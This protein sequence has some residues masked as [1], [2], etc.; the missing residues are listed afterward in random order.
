M[1]ESDNHQNNGGPSFV[2]SEIF[3]QENANDESVF[4]FTGL[5]NFEK[6]GVVVPR[7][8]PPHKR[9]DSKTEIRRSNRSK[10]EILLS[11]SDIFDFIA[12]MNN[13][14]FAAKNYISKLNQMHVN[15]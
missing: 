2:R 13:D 7:H 10:L 1:S 14:S 9:Q 8:L 5:L 15:P 3:D 4:D 11:Q 12:K 6:K